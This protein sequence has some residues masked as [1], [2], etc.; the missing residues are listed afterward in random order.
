MSVDPKL[1][2]A[3]M[4]VTIRGEQYKMSPLS[5]KDFGALTQWTRSQ[6]AKQAFESAKG[7]S[8]EMRDAVISVALRDSQKVEWYNEFGIRLWDTFDGWLEMFHLSLVKLHPR[9]N[10]E[11]LRLL[12]T[13]DPDPR[14]LCNYLHKIVADLNGFNSGNGQ[15]EGSE[16]PTDSNQ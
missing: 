6:Y 1:S 9:L 13:G 8:P 10:K 15:A 16:P 11:K 5:D 12:I 3:P 2:A 7:L 4:E 14:E